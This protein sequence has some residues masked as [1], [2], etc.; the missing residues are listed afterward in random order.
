MLLTLLHAPAPQ[1]LLMKC[2]KCQHENRADAKFCEEC[3]SPL[4]RACPNCGSEISAKAKFCPECA[5]PLAG[6][7]A[8]PRIA[9]LKSYTPRHLADKIL[10][11]KAALEGERKH[12]TV[13]FADIKGSTA[14]IEKLDPEEAAQKLGPAISLMMDAVHQYEGT[15]NE[16]RG[17]GIMALFGAPLAHEDHAVRACLAALA[18]RDAVAGAK[19]HAVELRIGLHSGEVLVRAIHNDLSMDYTAIGATVHLASRMEQIAPTGRIY[20]TAPT[21]ALA[22]GVVET[23]PLGPNPVKGISRGV[24]VFELVHRKELHTRWEA[25]SAHEL[26]AFVGR[27]GELDTLLMA[28]RRVSSGQGQLIALTGDAGMGKSRLAHEFLRTP[29]MSDW[30]LHQT[31]ASPYGVNAPFLPIAILFRSIFSIRDRDTKAEIDTK[32]R[33]GLVLYGQENAELLPAIQFLLNLSVEDPEWAKLDPEQRRS[34]VVE[35]LR[36]FLLRSTV[37]RPLLLLV[38]DLHWIDPETQQFLDT[39]ANSLGAHRLLLLATYRPEYQHSWT[40]KSYYTQIRIN[41]LGET[42][43]HEMLDALLGPGPE[44][45][46]I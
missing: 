34:R 13:L 5:H 31:G 1:G 15:V 29:R 18:I 16:V 19:E 24:E 25:R 22:K 8:Q 46:K 27:A 11:S 28:A 32:I 33:D 41:P 26:T 21:N 4:A 42:N 3:A 35:D 9:S 6:P 39:L 12:V 10:T 23:R 30:S 7:A 45:K 20:L 40:S 17:D 37:K 2:L 43:A 44:L 38:E 14:L 36:N